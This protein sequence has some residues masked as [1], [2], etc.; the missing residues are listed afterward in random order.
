[1]SVERDPVTGQLT[2]GHEWDGI[3]ELD[4]PTPSPVKWSYVLTTL[5]AAV[6][7]ILY[8]AWPYVSDFTRGILGH[9]TRSTVT[10]LVETARAHKAAFDRDIVE[11]D[12]DELA[13]DPEIRAKYESTIAVLYQDNCAACHG[14][15]LRGQNGFPDLTDDHWLWSDNLAEIET[16]IRDG[17]NSSSDDTRFAEMAGFGAL[18]MLPREDIEHVV[19]YV[20]AISGQAHEAEQSTKGAAVFEEHCVACHGEAGQGGM[21]LGAPSLVDDKWLYGSSRDEIYQTV[22]SGRMG[23]MPA[24]SDRLSTADIRKLVLYVKWQGDGR[25]E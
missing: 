18:E 6:L 16:T 19:Q 7:W 24:W 5:I 2:T 1:M 14:R 25:N 21:Q 20:L 10:T 22:W 4:T 11:G 3:T 9:S 13:E 15:D 23:V 17:I 12:L 8:P